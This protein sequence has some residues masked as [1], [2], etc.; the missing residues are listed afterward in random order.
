MFNAE[1]KATRWLLPYFHSS[2]AAVDAVQQLVAADREIVVKHI[3]ASSD[4]T[5]QANANVRLANADA[6]AAA[7]QYARAIKALKRALAR[8]ELKGSDA[9]QQ[10]TANSKLANA[11]RFIAA[12]RYSRAILALREAWLAVVWQPP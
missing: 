3:A 11:A 7:G 2:P 1:R 6:Y 9:L 12:G 10:A 5:A 4:P 8:G